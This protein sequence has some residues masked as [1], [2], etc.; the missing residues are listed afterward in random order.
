MGGGVGGSVAGSAVGAASGEII[1]GLFK[2]F[3]KK[4]KQPEPQPAPATPASPAAGSAVLFR[5]TTELTDVNDDKIPAERF[6]L[7]A[8][9]KKVSW[10]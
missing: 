5:I 10:K 3:G 4:K 2:R 8:G 1:S 9:W 6:E 7:P